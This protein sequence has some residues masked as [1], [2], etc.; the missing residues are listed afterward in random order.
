MHLKLRGGGMDVYSTSKALATDG[1]SRDWTKL[2]RKQLVL[3]L[4]KS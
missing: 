4:A 3:V 1:R 2:R